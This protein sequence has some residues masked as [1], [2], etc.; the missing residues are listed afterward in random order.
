MQRFLLL[1]L[2]T[3]LSACGAHSTTTPPVQAEL[4][5]RNVS[6]IL[7]QV[8]IEETSERMAA[9]L[10]MKADEELRLPLK[11]ATCIR[12]SGTAGVQLTAGASAEV[13]L[14]TQGPRA[15]NFPSC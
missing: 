9:S 12:V 3:L 8:E 7:L 11:T 6:G 15:M 4:L 2:G 14:T 10:P 5:L 1:V 13:V